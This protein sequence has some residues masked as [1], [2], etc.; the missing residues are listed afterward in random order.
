MPQFVR[1]V[2][3]IVSSEEFSDA[4]IG[5]GAIGRDFP[6]NASPMLPQKKSKPGVWP[7]LFGISLDYI[8][9][10]GAGDEI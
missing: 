4:Q 8:G 5:A 2:R 7:V 3:N 6:P 9:K 10:S 1:L